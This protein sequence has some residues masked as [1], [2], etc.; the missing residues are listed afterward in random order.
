MGRRPSYFHPFS[1]IRD[2]P[3]WLPIPSTVTDLHNPLGPAVPQSSPAMA[4]KAE[5]PEQKT[6]RNLQERTLC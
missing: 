1:G 4:G 6:V 5:C 2:V 3:S